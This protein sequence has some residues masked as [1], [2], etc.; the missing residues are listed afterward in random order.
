MT[1]QQKADANVSLELVKMAAICVVLVVIGYAAAYIEPDIEQ[2]DN[3]AY[4]QEYLRLQHVLGAVHNQW[5]IRGKPRY[6]N[7]NWQD[8][9]QLTQP[10][11]S[12]PKIVASTKVKLSVSGFPVLNTQ[13]TQG[14]EILWQQLMGASRSKLHLVSRYKESQQQCEFKAFDSAVIIYSLAS[15]TLSFTEAKAI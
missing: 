14:C 5:I 13:D 10:L 15:E 12:N 8:V 7:L 9:S 2:V 6:I 11:N 4:K 3:Q 1:P